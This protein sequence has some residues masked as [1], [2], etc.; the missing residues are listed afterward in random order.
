MKLTKR[1]HWLLCEALRRYCR[2]H[3]QD[4][5]RPLIDAWTGLGSYTQY[6]PALDSG[7]MIYATSPN[8]GYTTWWRL[9]EK[10]AK[11]VQGWLDTGFTHADI[12]AGRLPP[13]EVPA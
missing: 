1:K 2:F 7:L 11:I 5:R 12:E 13:A 4:L 10:G 8:P 3:L 6:K 9:T